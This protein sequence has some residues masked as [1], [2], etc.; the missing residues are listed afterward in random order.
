MAPVP[1]SNSA[2]CRKPAPGVGGEYRD[3]LRPQ[4]AWIARGRRHH[5]E[6]GLVA[7]WNHRANRLNGLAR[8]EATQCRRHRLDQVVH[9]QDGSYIPFSQQSKNH[10]EC[11]VLRAAC[12]VLRAA[13]YMLLRSEHQDEH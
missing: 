8:R 7:D 11:L 1:G 10:R 9:R 3:Q 5:A 2:V 13:C 4:R 12:C 6:E